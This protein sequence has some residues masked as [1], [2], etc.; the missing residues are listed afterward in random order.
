LNTIENYLHNQLGL[1]PKNAKL[2]A[3]F[4]K[5]ETISKGTYL[6]K[7]DSYSRKMV[8]LKKGYVRCFFLMGKKKSHTGCIGRIMLS[9]MYPVFIL[10][11]LLNGIFKH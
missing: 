2:A 10:I 11:N 4:Y 7:Q 8:F 6:I 9:M 5:K 1:T 3:T